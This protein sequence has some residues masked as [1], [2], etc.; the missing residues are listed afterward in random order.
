MQSGALRA[1]ICLPCGTG[2]RKRPHREKRAAPRG[3]ATHGVP[4]SA[5][6]LMGFAQ[7]GVG[8]LAS[9]AVSRID[10]DHHLILGIVFAACGALCF[11]AQALI[12]PKPPAGS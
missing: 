5:S 7:M 9:L 1:P 11:L 2:V 4:G 3:R 12:L 10:G 8:V 6:A